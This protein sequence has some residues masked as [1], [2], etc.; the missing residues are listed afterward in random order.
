MELDDLKQAWQTIDGRL[1]QQNALLLLTR[2]EKQTDKARLGLRPLF[3]GQ[4]AQMLFGA[5]IVLMAVIF[6]SRPHDSAL[7]IAAGVIVH[8]YGVVVIAM[9]GRTLGMIRGID[10]SAPV[11]AIQQQ[12]A[13]LR[14]FYII[15]GMLAGLPWW[16]LWM[17][18]LIVLSGLGG[19]T[20]GQDWLLSWLS[21][22]AVIGV[23]GLLATWAFHRWSQRRSRARGQ[24]LEESLGGGSLRAA[25][26]H[27]DVLAQ[28]EQE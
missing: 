14:R 28:F 8:V 7:L 17:P 5:L 4:V 16:L 25:Q 15:N 19:N 22:G 27:V 26:R 9:A 21:A 13:R 3:W 2:R 11:V 18:F 24:S 23:T 10:Y 20:D 12:L 1:Q 6:W